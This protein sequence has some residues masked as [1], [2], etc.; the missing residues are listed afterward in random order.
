VIDLG[1]LAKN[2]SVSHTYPIGTF[3][4]R[5]LVTD[6]AGTEQAPAAQV[7]H[8]GSLVTVSVG[9]TDLGGLNVTATADVRG[10]AV[11]RYEWNF[12]PTASPV[13]TT[14]PQAWFTYSAPGYKA[15]VLKAT[16]ADGRVITGSSSVVVG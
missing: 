14:E 1:T 4:A 3:T 8:V 6:M 2:S 7:V 12:D 5:L 9:A 15:V 10:A 11:V 16:L 13:V